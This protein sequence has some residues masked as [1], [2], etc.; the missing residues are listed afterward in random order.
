[1][2]E[3][4]YDPNICARCKTID[5]LMRCQYIDLTIDEAKRENRLILDGGRSRVL[6]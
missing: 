6:D 5:C 2:Y 4:K 1:M 3:L